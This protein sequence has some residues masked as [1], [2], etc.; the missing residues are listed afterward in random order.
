M[1]R[2][3][4]TPVWAGANDSDAD[5]GAVSLHGMLLLLLL[6]TP[7]APSTRIAGMDIAK[8]Y[9]GLNAGN[10]FGVLIRYG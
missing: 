5:F 6:R 10:P 7:V 9:L 3:R 2:Q 4:P 8:F 1:S